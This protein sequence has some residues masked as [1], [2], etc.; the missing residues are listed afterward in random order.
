M[1]YVMS[2]GVKVCGV[3]RTGKINQFCFAQISKILNLI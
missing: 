1:A 3:I 2:V